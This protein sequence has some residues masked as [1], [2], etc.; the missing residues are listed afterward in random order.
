MAS[1]HHYI[2]RAKGLAIVLVVIGHVVAKEPPPGAEWYSTLKHWIYIFHM[3]LFIFLSGLTF[4]FSFRAPTGIADYFHT[5]RRRTARLMTAYFVI[6]LLIF[7]GKLLFQQFTTVDNPVHGIAGLLDL[8]LRPMLSFSRFLWYVYALSLLYAALPLLFKLS[9][10]RLWPLIVL[11][12]LVP[13]LPTSTF[14]AWHKLQELAFYFVLGIVAGRH[15]PQFERLLQRAWLPSFFVFLLMLPWVPSDS[16]P[17]AICCIFAI[18]GLAGLLRTSCVGNLT[19]LQRIG[20]FTL[21]IYLFN[22]I[23]IGLVKTAW[24]ATLGWEGARFVPAF[25]AL[26][27]AGV[28]VPMAMKHWLF[29][30]VPALDRIT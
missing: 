2:D 19:T 8:A 26:A 28:L 29:T 30:R 5:L 18:V 25:F 13:L 6:G 7:F 1:R 23:V 11:A 12:A 22:T 20:T 17:A 3:P 27:L 16:V 14:L 9:G 24:V 4:G 15:H 10:E 21:S